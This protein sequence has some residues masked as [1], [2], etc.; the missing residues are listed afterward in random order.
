MFILKKVL[1]VI[2]CIFALIGMVMVGGYVAIKLGWTNT[3]GMVDTGS[4]FLKASETSQTPAWVNTPEWQT[5]AVAAAADA[6]AINKAAGQSAI[7]ARL[8]VAQLVA[9]Q[10]RL[11]NTER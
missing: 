9:E 11:Y 4:R 1:F 3:K 6:P 10:L 5:L 7:P 2:I 8:I